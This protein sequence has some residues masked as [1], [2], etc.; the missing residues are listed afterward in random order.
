MIISRTPLRFSFFGGGSD[1]PE[2]YQKHGGT[3]VSTTIN[4]YIYITMN[5]RFTDDLRLSYS[6]TEIVSDVTELR[7]TLAK[8]CLTHFG[9]KSGFE[10]TSVADI[11]G[12]GSGLGSSSSFSVGLINLLS[13]KAG[14]KISKYDLAEEAVYIERDVSN[15]FIG[16]QDQY[17]ASFG[18]LNLINF[19]TNGVEVKKI[20]LSSQAKRH[21]E[22]SCMTFYTG[23]T[24]SASNVLEDQFSSLSDK[25]K[26][27]FPKEKLETL[28]YFSSLA[29]DSKNYLYNGDVE[30]LGRSL[31]KCWKLK[32]KLGS[33]VSTEVI[34]NIYTKA[35]SAG[36]F[37][38]KILGAGGGG[39]MLFIVPKERQE[40]VREALKDFK[41]LPALFEENGSDI[42]YNDE[43]KNE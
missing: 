8:N 2:F 41:E 14:K 33:S 19:S 28:K 20:D 18:G 17:A 5:T 42:I 12:K 10:L 13:C 39:F 25:N 26:S 36:A 32:R 30:W 7:H 22:A 38:G 24:R 35:M 34:D 6:E 15:N 31:D 43:E 40:R 37:G 16:V 21:I 9:L 1:F 29:S 27:E 4:K 11:H 3:V 23:L